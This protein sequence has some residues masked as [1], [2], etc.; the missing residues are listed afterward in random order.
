VSLWRQLERSGTEDHTRD[1]LLILISCVIEPPLNGGNKLL[2]GDSSCSWNVYNI[3]ENVNLREQNPYKSLQNLSNFTKISITLYNYC[4]TSALLGVI[5][6]P[7]REYSVVS[8]C[9]TVKNPGWP[10]LYS[11]AKENCCCSFLYIH[12]FTLPVIQLS[13]APKNR[14]RVNKICRNSWTS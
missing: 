9:A 11:V 2:E 6:R 14:I 1:G 13:K 8:A 7:P 3:S 12:I 4:T 10:R 5:P